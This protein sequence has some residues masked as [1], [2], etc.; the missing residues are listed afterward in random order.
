MCEKPSAITRAI[1]Q[2]C[3]AIPVLQLFSLTFS[4][5]ALPEAG[6]P[7][8]ASPP[9]FGKLFC[10]ACLHARTHA[11][12][13]TENSSRIPNEC[14]VCLSVGVRPPLFVFFAFLWF[15]ELKVFGLGWVELAGLGEQQ[16]ARSDREIGNTIED[17]QGL[18]L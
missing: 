8:V 11:R 2:Y 18:S 9:Q 7:K 1:L 3:Y 10:L 13:H 15:F 5:L 16:F 12:T 14:P 6:G 17:L 4:M